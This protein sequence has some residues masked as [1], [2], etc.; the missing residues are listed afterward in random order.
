MH[1]TLELECGHFIRVS[2]KPRDW[3][4]EQCPECGWQ[5]IVEVYHPKWY[6][7]CHECYY[8]RAHGLSRTYAEQSRDKHKAQTGHVVSVLFYEGSEHTRVILSPPEPT[9]REYGEPPY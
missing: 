5:N 6:S 7:V 8:R 3:D 4:T 9:S 2:S 1:Y